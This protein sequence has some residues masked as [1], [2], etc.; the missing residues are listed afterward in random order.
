MTLSVLLFKIIAVGKIIDTQLSL[1]INDYIQRMGRDSRLEIF[2]VKDSSPENEG[3]KI[4]EILEKENGY[5]F[6]LSEEG[7][8]YD[9][10]SF[11][12]KLENINGKIIFVIGGPNGLSNS[13]KSCS[14]EILSLSKM[15]FTHE[16]ARLL[17]MEQLFRAGTILNN[18]KYHRI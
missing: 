10:I 7:R 9:S 12:K 8:Q 4:K 1:L 11:A 15:T 6:V 13:V 5:N 2:E 16:M 17:L 14:Q 18:R 3:A